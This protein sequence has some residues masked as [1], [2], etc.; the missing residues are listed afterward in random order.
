MKEDC[1]WKKYSKLAGNSIQY[2][3]LLRTSCSTHDHIPACDLVLFECSQ[4]QEQNKS[5]K[6]KKAVIPVLKV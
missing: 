1:I 6:K 3:V 4:K 5:L 2:I